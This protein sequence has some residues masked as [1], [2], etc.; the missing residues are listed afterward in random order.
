MPVDDSRCKEMIHTF[1]QKNRLPTSRQTDGTA[2][3][4]GQGSCQL[5]EYSDSELGLMVLPNAQDAH[6]RR[7]AGIRKKC[8]E[9]GMT[10]RQ[11]GEDE[12]ALSFDPNNRQQARLAI[13]VTGARPKCQLSP[14]HRAKLLA[15]GFQKRQ[16]PTLKGVFSDK[17]PLETGVVVNACPSAKTRFESP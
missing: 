15:V 13:K 3:I 4:R 2:V 16:H 1:A 14:E 8:L 5:Y 10:L 17:K 11:N 7:W 12:A 9:A 6:P